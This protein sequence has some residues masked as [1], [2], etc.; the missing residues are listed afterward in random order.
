MCF[1][2]VIKISIMK[3]NMIFDNNSLFKEFKELVLEILKKNGFTVDDISEK[4]QKGFNFEISA[5]RIKAIVE[6]KLQR[7]KIAEI[8]LV[9]RACQQLIF[10]IKKYSDTIPILIISNYVQ[11]SLIKEMHDNYGIIIWDDRVLFSL[12]S[13]FP[14]LFSHLQEILY[15]ACG[16]FAKDHSV[17]IKV[18]KEIIDKLNKVPIIDKKEHII[19]LSG[20]SLCNE[21]KEINAGKRDFR[22]FEDVNI[23]I[24]KYL[25]GKDLELWKDQ[26]Q[27]GDN[28]HRFDL[29]CR[30][31]P[32]SNNFWEELL[33]DFKSRYVVFEFKNYKDEIKQGQIYT[34]EKYLFKTALRS[35]AFII[36]RKGGDINAHKAAIG[37]LNEAGKLIIILS[38]KDV[39]DMLIMK[40]GGDEPAELLRKK[41]DNLLTGMSR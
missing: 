20:V 37:A 5:E 30:L 15:K 40:D 4:E 10:A 35:I 2:V 23:K 27:T 22:K 39:F 21:L 41:I 19:E 36:A 13:K 14:E 17:D 28:L 29:L 9:K 26:N 3:K 34:T 32:S 7:S 25:F 12:S 33:N 24:L 11:D 18:V 31:R 38:T 1:N 6:I 16:G 8:N